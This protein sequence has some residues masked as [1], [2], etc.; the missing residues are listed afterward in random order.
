MAEPRSQSAPIVTPTLIA[1][2]RTLAAALPELLVE[3]RQVANTVASGWH[4]RRRAG[5]GEDFWQFRPFQ[6]GE[7][8]R[9]I[10]WRRSAR[11]DGHLYVR[12]QEMENAHTVWVAPDLSASMRFRSELGPVFKRDRAL[13]L[14][15][16]LAEL[17]ARSGERVG[18]L[19]HGRPVASRTAAERL[20]VTL[21]HVDEDAGRPDVAA[22]RRFHE[23]VYLGD[24][25]D[26]AET[27][28]DDLLRLAR[29][30]ARV[31]V[32][33]VLDPVEETFPFLGRTEFLD[34][35]TGG[36][37]TAGRAEAWRAGYLAALARH[38]DRIR[39]LTRLPG[40]SF[41][42]HHTDRPPTEALLAL[43]GRLSA[44]MVHGHV[45]TPVEGA[46]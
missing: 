39:E 7:A 24:V 23:V 13:V 33:Q 31:H 36:R 8:A 27:I 21:A 42:V 46:A 22:V 6:F 41:L 19:G 4:G 44:S 29:T 5:T 35:E 14:T 10:D 16:A 30:G 43:H 40:W 11:D 34:P 28:A 12:E 45:G 17:L 9:R 25:L 20:A 1:G 15:I 38:R 32:V 3:A 37:I 26:P 2:A 18:L